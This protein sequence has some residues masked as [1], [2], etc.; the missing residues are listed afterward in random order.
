LFRPHLI[1]EIL[2]IPRYPLSYSFVET[3]GHKTNTDTCEPNDETEVMSYT[4]NSTTA[5][6]GIIGIIATLIQTAINYVG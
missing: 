6:S 3:S 5:C 2:E 1:I 4:A